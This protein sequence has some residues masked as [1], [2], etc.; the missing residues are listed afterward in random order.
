LEIAFDAAK[1]TIPRQCSDL[2]AGAVAVGNLVE[3]SGQQCVQCPPAWFTREM[4]LAKKIF[5]DGASQACAA[6]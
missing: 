2:D 3:A 1:S 5:F 6:S 4:V